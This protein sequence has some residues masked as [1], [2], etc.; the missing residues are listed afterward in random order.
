MTM[1]DRQLVA[2]AETVVGIKND[3]RFWDLARGNDGVREGSKYLRSR[4]RN[5]A[6]RTGNAADADRLLGL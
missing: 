5:G 6:E 3:A 4:I 2:C 1:T